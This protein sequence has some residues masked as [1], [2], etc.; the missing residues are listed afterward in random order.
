MPTTVRSRTPRAGASI[1]WSM[2]VIHDRVG[3][4]LSRP[5]ADRE[6][7][8]GRAVGDVRRGDLGD[9]GEP[10]AVTHRLRLQPGKPAGVRVERRDR[11]GVELQRQGAVELTARRPGE[12]VDQRGVDVLVLQHR[13]RLGERERTVHLQVRL[14][15]R[16]PRPDCI[17]CADEGEREALQVVARPGDGEADVGLLEADIGPDAS[18]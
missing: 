9:V 6:D 7:H 5:V 16:R 14:A 17:K 18:G 11:V 15:D 12:R 1:R 8:C 4:E 2:P 3:G 10:A 13:D